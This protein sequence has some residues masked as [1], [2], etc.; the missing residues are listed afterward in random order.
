VNQ[1]SVFPPNYLDKLPKTPRFD[2]VS[3]YAQERHADRNKPLVPSIAGIKSDYYLPPAT[4]AQN[5]SQIKELPFSATA[6]HLSN[7]V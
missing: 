4:I 6:L 5:A 1:I 7:Q 3:W 2:R